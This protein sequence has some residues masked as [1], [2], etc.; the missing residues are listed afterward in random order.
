MKGEQRLIIATCEK[1]SVED[2]N[3]M[4]D[5]KAGLDQI[6]E[7]HPNFVDM[8]SREVF[9]PTNAKNVADPIPARTWSSSARQRVALMQSRS[10][11]RIGIPRL[12]NIYTYAPL[13]NAYFESLGVQPENVIYSAST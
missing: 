7:Q 12:L 8:A 9:R 6:R 4:K 3:E 2:V 11:I 5:I 13:F 10:K 1:G